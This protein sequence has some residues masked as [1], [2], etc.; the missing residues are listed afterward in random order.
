MTWTDTAG[1]IDLGWG[2]C[3]LTAEDEALTLHA[4]A[5]DAAD[6]RRLQALL[7]ARLE[8]FGRRDHL[9]VTWRP[10]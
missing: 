10:D 9:T 1:A 3:T 4:E 2:R 5:D 6:L 8:Q 7:G